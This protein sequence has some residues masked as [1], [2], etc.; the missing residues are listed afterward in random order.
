M[1]VLSAIDFEA[2]G[3]D[4]QFVE[5]LH[6]TGFGVLKNHPL[7]KPLIRS[8]YAHWTEFFASGD[9]AGY[10]VDRENQDGFFSMADA[11]SAKGQTHQDLKEYFHFY[12]WGRCPPELRDELIQYYESA[13]VFAATLLSWIEQYSP[14]SIAESYSEPLSNMIK[15]SEVTLLR[16]LHYPPISGPVSATRAAPHEDINLITILPMSSADGLEVLGGND[17]WIPVPADFD[18]VVVNIGDMLQEATAGHFPSTTHRV[19]N[20]VGS[21]MSVSR[22][23]LPLF[24]HPRPD[25]VLSERYTAKSYLDE[26]LREL[27]VA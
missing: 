5:S 25:V 23:S 13:H 18:H 15:D 10:A 12:P 2:P 17:Q 8:I 3:S 1:T 7:D 14:G 20:P 21:D 26:R 4:Q 9:A 6:A 27:G 11:E 19:V 16:I 22:M 24:L